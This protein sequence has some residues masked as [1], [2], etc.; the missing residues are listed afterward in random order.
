MELYAADA[1][2]F[3]CAKSGSGL[4]CTLTLCFFAAKSTSGIVSF[5]ST[6]STDRIGIR[7]GAILAMVLLRGSLGKERHR[8]AEESQRSG[9]VP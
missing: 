9:L 3:L 7:G 6:V 2:I 4:D 1:T 8:L 5:C